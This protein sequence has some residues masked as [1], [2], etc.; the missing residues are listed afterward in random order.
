[1]RKVV[2]FGVLAAAMAT[3][4]GASAA[5]AGAESTGIA[6][7]GTLTIGAERMFGVSWSQTS[8]EDTQ[9]QGGGTVTRN[10]KD[11]ST[12]FG[13]LWNNNAA[14]SPYLVPR[15]GVDFTVIPNL[16]IGGTIGYVHSSLSFDHT[17]TTTVGATTQSVNTSGDNGAVSGFLLAPRVGY[18][19]PLGSVLG[20]WL[21]GGISYYNVGSEGPPNANGN[22]DSNTLSG[23]GLNLDPQLVI[24]PVE[25]FAITVG[26]AV[27]LPLSGTNKDEAANGAT[28]VS[29]SYTEHFTN[30]GLTAG[31]IGWL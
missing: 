6:E 27:D 30:I 20:L 5:R 31:I 4:S 16:T 15:I 19:I 2:L 28:V 12:T 9:N 29:R 13:L 1:M 25:H 14:L 3:V 17:T 24:S 22:K 26:L 8:T 23:F 7:K 10:N 21:R 18:V 11:S